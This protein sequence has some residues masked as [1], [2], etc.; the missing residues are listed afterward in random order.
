[1]DIL[2]ADDHPVIREGLK[3]IIES[4][5]GMAVV[6]QAKDAHQALELAR[7]VHWDVAVIDYSMPGMSGSDLVKQIK[8]CHPGRPVLIVSVHR[9][10]EQGVEAL[11]AGAAGYL[12]KESAVDQLLCA[13]AKVVAGGRYISPVLAERLADQFAR[14]SERPLHENLSDRELLVMPLLASGRSIKDISEELKLSSSTISTYRSRIF[15]KL[16][17]V[18]KTDLVRYAI[19]HQIID[20]TPAPDAE[21]TSRVSPLFRGASAE[22]TLPPSR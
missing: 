22:S 14:G 11:Q 13:I 12:N 17:L 6:A 18:R 7:R 5:A 4:H 16:C 19:R 1:M 15:R 20:D 21:W 2:I 8:R 9:E 10:A 3:D